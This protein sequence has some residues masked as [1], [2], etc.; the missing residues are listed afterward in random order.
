MVYSNKKRQLAVSCRHVKYTLS[1]QLLDEQLR[2][3]LLSS[4]AHYQWF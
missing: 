1:G 2:L 4:I 3:V